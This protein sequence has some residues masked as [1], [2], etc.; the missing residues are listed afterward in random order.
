MYDVDA[1]ALSRSMTARALGPGGG[2][3]MYGYDESSGIGA[4]CPRQRPAHRDERRVEPIH[5]HLDL[6]FGDDERWCDHDGIAAFA[7][8][9][10]D[11]RPHDESDVPRRRRESLGDV[12]L[13]RERCSRLLVLD[14][15]YA[16]QQPAAPHV[17]HVRT[18]TQPC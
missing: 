6:V 13:A 2:T 5:D 8:G 16:R 14:E 10:A 12:R 15:L 1:Q 11:V 9:V 18:L 17:T 3:T 7:I 4:G